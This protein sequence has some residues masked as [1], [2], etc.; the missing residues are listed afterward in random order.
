MDDYPVY[1][2]PDDRYDNQNYV[3]FEV[4]IPT[5]IGC[6]I[7]EL[8]ETIRNQNDMFDDNNY[9]ITLSLENAQGNIVETR[10][11]Q[12]L[13]TNDN[14]PGL[15]DLNDLNYDPGRHRI[16]MRYF[17]PEQLP[18]QLGNG[19]Y[20][21]YRRKS[22][23]KKRK[24]TRKSRRKSRRKKRKSTRKSRKRKSQKKT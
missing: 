6:T 10:D 1:I 23:R 17:P 15:N 22:R 16:L 13:I 5:M 18:E 20:K 21:I 12:I 19:N 7:R 14:N 2:S 8:K 24:S 11:E 3:R 4:Q 9:T